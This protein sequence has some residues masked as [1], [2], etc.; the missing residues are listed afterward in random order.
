MSKPALDAL[1]QQCQKPDGPVVIEVDHLAPADANHLVSA[2]AK[3]DIKARIIDLA[4]VTSKADLLKALATAFSFPSHFGHNWDALVDSWS[5]LSWLPARGYV[6]ILLNA[7]AF[8]DAHRPTHDTFLTICDDVAKR[9]S[10][11][12]AKIVFKVVRAGTS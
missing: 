3:H 6:T 1:L 8:R 9:W 11:H 12:D 2:L 4:A 7:N 10:D 5:D